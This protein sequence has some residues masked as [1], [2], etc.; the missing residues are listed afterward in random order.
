VSEGRHVLFLA[1]N[2][3]LSIS[4]R[5]PG[6]KSAPAVAYK[7]QLVIYDAGPGAFVQFF[8]TLHP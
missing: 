1:V 3:V 8:E 7:K 5:G 4:N 2:P 6:I